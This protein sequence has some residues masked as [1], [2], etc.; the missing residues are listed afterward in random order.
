MDRFFIETWNHAECAWVERP[1]DFSTL[2][3]ALGYAEGFIKWRVIKKSIE[4]VF[5]S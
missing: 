3:E 1:F 5:R 2:E 4:V